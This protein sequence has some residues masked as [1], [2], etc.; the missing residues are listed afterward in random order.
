MSWVAWATAERV[1]L[2]G[3]D[4]WRELRPVEGRLPRVRTADGREVT[5]FAGNDYLGLGSHPAVGRAAAEAA[6]GAGT[7]AGASRLV[8][9]TTPAH[10]ELERAIARWRGTERALVFA[11]GYAANVG[12]VT[13]FGVEGV[14]IFSDERNHASIVDGCR[15]AR[16]EVVR[17][18]HLD[19]DQLA[20]GLRRCRRAI[21][22]TDS[23]FS[24]DGDVA[25][26]DELARLCAEH[27]ALLVLDEAHAVLGPV[28]RLGG[29]ECLRVGTLSK[30]LGALGGFVAGPAALVELVANRARTFVYTTALSPP[31]VAAAREALR[32]LEG[33]EGSTRLERLRAHVERLRPGQPSPIVPIVLGDDARALAASAALLRR[34]L[35]VPA[36]RPPTVPEGTARLRITLSSLHGEDDLDA[37]VDALDSL[38]LAPAPPFGDA[39]SKE[40]AR[41]ASTAPAP[42]RRA[43]APF[44]EGGGAPTFVVVSGTGTDVGKTWVAAAALRALVDRGLVVAAR[45]PFQSFSPG[46]GP[47]DAEV[48]AAASGEDPDLVCPPDSS[49]PV[50]LAP[51]MAAEVLGA[52]LPGTEEVAARLRE[53]ASTA[54]VVLVEGAGGLASPL[55][56]DGDTAALARALRAA[57]VVLVAPPGLG[58]ISSVRLCVAALAGTRVAVVLNHFDPAADLHQRNRAWLAERDGLEVLVSPLELA[59][60]I[61]RL[62]RKGRGDGPATVTVDAGEGG[63]R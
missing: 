45:K 22:V 44:S 17:Y 42:R 62:A 8:V 60:R 25:P 9:G 48:L 38:D 20:E 47:T 41:R 15:L 55:T 23:V 27:G 21:V 2:A 5:C 32:V 59:D 43:A 61:E 52:A 1:R 26:V 58:T 39:G 18:R 31:D 6:L 51:P 36:I 10:V 35:L 37:L 50:P 54:G 57:L 53:G 30:H 12:V 29:A 13:T 19:L 33:P 34:G 49:F 40:W 4:R 11:S 16:G 28:P 3:L 14:T 56:A 46:A 63:R 7:G 24:M